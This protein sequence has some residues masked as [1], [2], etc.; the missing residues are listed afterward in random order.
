MS[1]LSINN[2]S[3]DSNANLLPEDDEVPV[4]G[5]GG[6]SWQQQEI[7]ANLGGVISSDAFD[8]DAIPPI[9]L[10]TTCEMENNQYESMTGESEYNDTTPSGSDPFGDLFSYPHPMSW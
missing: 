1:A 2:S 3:G 5:F 9:E 10:G 6:Y 7:W 8:M 4:L